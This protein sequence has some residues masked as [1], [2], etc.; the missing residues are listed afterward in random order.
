MENRVIT[1][2]QDEVRTGLCA[3][4]AWLQDT[5][6]EGVQVLREHKKAVLTVAAIVVGVAGIVGGLLALLGR[7]K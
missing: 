6:H 7:K 2:D 1:F 3:V 5:Y 4:K